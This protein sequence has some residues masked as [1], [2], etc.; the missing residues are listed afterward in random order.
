MNQNLRRLNII[1][2]TYNQIESGIYA[3]VLQE[4]GSNRRIPIIIGESEAQ[5]IECKLQNIITARPLTHDLF[6]NTLTA[7]GHELQGVVIY[8]MSN[9]VFAADLWI[10]G[11]GKTTKVDSRSSDAIALA[12]RASAPIY[13]S[14]S[15]IEEVGFVASDS[16]DATRGQIV[17]PGCEIKPEDA[18]SPD[19]NWSCVTDS[20]L[21]ELLQSA[22]ETEYYEL[23]AKIKKEIDRRKN[24]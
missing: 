23:A 6:I 7:L 22:L 20:G 8:K 21:E 9:G 16:R 4:A 14:A 3:V 11:D 17:I 15:L 5:S 1:G 18:M 10:Y 24:R 12:M 13:A 2:I 19:F